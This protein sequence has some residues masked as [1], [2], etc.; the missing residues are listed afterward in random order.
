M[1]FED[2]FNQPIFNV[3]LLDLDS[4]ESH[5]CGVIRTKWNNYR[6]ELCKTR[7]D[8]LIA[9]WDNVPPTAPKEN[10]LISLSTLAIAFRMPKSKVK[11]LIDRKHAIDSG[12]T[13]RPSHRPS[14]ITSQQFELVKEFIRKREVDDLDPP[15]I[16]EVCEFI[17][18]TFGVTYHSTWINS[19]VKKSNGIYIVEAEPLEDRTVMSYTLREGKDK[20]GYEIL[21]R[22]K[23]SFDLIHLLVVM[24]SLMCQK[25]IKGRWIPG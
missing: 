9:L 18:N 14:K 19:M 7:T 17:S 2:E 13:F 12:E 24:D 5:L 15:E 25:W 3:E 10:W 21:Y 8:Q 23:P 20:T 1:D 16:E 6:V 4:L 11:R 22:V